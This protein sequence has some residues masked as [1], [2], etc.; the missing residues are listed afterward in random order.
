MI[1]FVTLQTRPGTPTYGA[2]KGEFSFVITLT[3]TGKFHASLKKLG[4]VIWD[5]SRVDLGYFRTFHEATEACET[6][7][8]KHS[9]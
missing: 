7:H 9:Q 8:R 6:Y 5:G 1:E 4:A 3:E 2:I